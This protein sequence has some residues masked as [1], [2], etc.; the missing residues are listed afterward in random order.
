MKIPCGLAWGTEWSIHLGSAELT[1]GTFSG[2]IFEWCNFEPN[3]L[4]TVDALEYYFLEDTS[5]R[6]RLQG[7]DP[8]GSSLSFHVETLPAYGELI[9]L[10]STQGVLHVSSLK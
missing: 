8:E 6:R 1:V 9:W 10:S 5:G 4:P 3:E 2:T 7:S